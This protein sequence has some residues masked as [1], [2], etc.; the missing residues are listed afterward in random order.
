MVVQNCMHVNSK[1]HYYFIDL[2]FQMPILTLITRFEQMRLKTEE[3]SKWDKDVMALERA[4]SAK[5]AGMLIV[6]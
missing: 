5:P 1:S 4:L 6:S 3:T 2:L